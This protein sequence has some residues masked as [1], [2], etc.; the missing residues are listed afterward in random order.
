M[1]N[2]ILDAFTDELIRELNPASLLHL[3][4][5]IWNVFTD[6]DGR[7][8]DS[9]TTVEDLPIGMVA[10]AIEPPPPTTACVVS[11]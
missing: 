11:S 6:F 2:P 1:T 7:V 10:R 5:A 4:T 3:N 9:L 8:V